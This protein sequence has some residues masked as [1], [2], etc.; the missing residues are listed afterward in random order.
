MGAYVEVTDSTFQAEV[1]DSDL[2]VVVDFW[3]PWCGPCRA[4]APHL[5]A[6]GAELAG[7]VKIAKVNVDH[8]QKY[9]MEYGVQGIPKL[10]L[11]KGGNVVDEITGLPGNPRESIKQF[12]MQG[13]S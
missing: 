5:D 13:L 7:Q 6:V 8:N 11:F 4:L 2:P 3:A 12:A 1:L 9:A 10:I